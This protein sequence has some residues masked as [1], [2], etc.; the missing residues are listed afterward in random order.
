LLAD[1]KYDVILIENELSQLELDGLNL[2]V[3]AI[4]YNGTIANTR[5]L[6]TMHTVYHDIKRMPIMLDISRKIAHYL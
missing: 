3:D 6:I 1:Q 2:F 4:N 5:V